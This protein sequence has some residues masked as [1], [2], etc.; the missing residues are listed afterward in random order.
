M[1]RRRVGTRHAAA[2][3]PF[4][5]EEFGTDAAAPRR[6]AVYIHIGASMLASMA[7]VLTVPWFT[8]GWGSRR[9]LPAFAA[10]CL[11][12]ASAAV[13]AAVTISKTAR[14]RS[15][16]A[17]ARAGD[18]TRFYPW[19]NRMAAAVVVV[20]LVAML[21]ICTDD[22]ATWG[23]SY[24]GLLFSY[25]CLHPVSGISPMVP[26][27]LLLFAWYLW[28][29]FQTARLRFSAMNRPRLPG[30]ITSA[31]VYPL[32]VTDES[33]DNCKPP[34]SSCLFRNIDCLLITRELA[35]RFFTR[36]SGQTLDVSLI[37]L[38]FVSFFLCAI[39]LDIQSLDRFLYHSPFFLTA[40]EWLIAIFFYPLVMI[41]LAGW[42]RVLF[43]WAALKDGLLDQLERSPF[44]LAFSRL[45]EVDWVTMLSQSGLNI[46]W[47]DM[48]RSTES[49]RQLMNNREI[50]GVA[51]VTGWVSL[52][53]AYAD[54]STQIGG[55]LQYIGTQTTSLPEEYT[56]EDHDL[57][58][59]D[60]RRELCFIYAIERR[61][62][63][64][65]ERLLE[66][67][68]I[69]YWNETRIGFVNE[70]ESDSPGAKHLVDAPQEPLHIM[71]AEEFLAI[72]YVALIRNVVV[73]IR[74]LMVF[75]SVAFVLAIVAWI[76]YPFQPH[77]LIGW[78]FTLLML[79]LS[80]GFIWVFAQM[81]R[82]PILS[83]ITATTPNQLG[84]DFYIHL[85]TFGAVPV[86]TWLAYQFPEIG[87]SVFRLLQPS[88]QV[89]K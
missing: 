43:V 20:V 26:V 79:C 19:F 81:H 17:D 66:H 3:R 15:P 56:E 49:L 38:Y 59:P 35:G 16:Q 78:C 63:I 73:N 52:N 82:N 14:Y 69:P 25:R 46:R 8:F 67:V 10:A 50:M 60:S 27:L 58:S 36:W 64:F 77:Y 13:A 75:V 9:Y 71:L 24:V 44:R 45:S 40:Y 2:L 54:L 4:H 5:R 53:D 76:S 37:L 72:R 55:L 68:L 65:C 83:R 29:I 6:R 61:Y 47:R 42:L 11:A 86:L 22:P 39:G 32:Y 84:T 57:P 62:A 18:Q 80:V 70:Q 23:T 51:G 1:P 41:A 34:L 74:R 21:W 89:A 7:L 31:S 48:A 88:L 28:A 30:W 33:L 85:A 12:L 87:G